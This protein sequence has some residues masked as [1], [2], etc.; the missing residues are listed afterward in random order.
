MTLKCFLLKVFFLF[1]WECVDGHQVLKG[2][3]CQCSDEPC[4]EGK[5]C[6]DGECLDEMPVEGKVCV[7]TTRPAQYLEVWPVVTNTPNA[8]Y[9]FEFDESAAKTY[10]A[11]S[12]ILSFLYFFFCTWKL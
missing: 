5:F 9:Y 4:P 11:K 6:V 7:S 3:A 1:L 8:G 10:F 2:A 12:K